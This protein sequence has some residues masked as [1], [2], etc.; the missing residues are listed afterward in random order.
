MKPIADGID[1]LLCRVRQ[2]GWT[3]EIEHGQPKLVRESEGRDSLPAGLIREVR[4]HR[5]LI[6]RH[7]VYSRL[8]VRAMGRPIYGYDS[9]D[10][11][12]SRPFPKK[13]IPPEWDRMCV[14]G[15]AN[16]QMM[17]KLIKSE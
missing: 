3:V 11:R 9:D 12:I 16:W 14:S 6:I 7:L 17:P 10:G 2:L 4:L 5:V 13:G 8:L 15:D 1:L